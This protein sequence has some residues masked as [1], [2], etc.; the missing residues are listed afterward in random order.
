MILRACS[1]TSGPPPVSST[2]SGTGTAV[3]RGESRE[4]DARVSTFG[5][6]ARLYLPAASKRPMQL[7]FRAKPYATGALIVYVNGK[8]VG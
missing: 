1:S 7:R 4:G 8:T 5:K 3:G 6:T 2:P